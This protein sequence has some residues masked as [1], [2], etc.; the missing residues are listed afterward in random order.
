MKITLINLAN[1]FEF[2]QS[3]FEFSFHLL[4]LSLETG[5]SM[6]A[7]KLQSKLSKIKI[8]VSDVDGVLTDGGLYYSAE[9]LAFKK[10]NVKDGM[11]VVRLKELGFLTGIISTDDSQIIKIRAQ[12][13]KMNFAITGT[14]DKSGKVTELCRQNNLTLEN[15]AFIGDDV[16]D[17]DIMKIVG[18]CACPSDAIPEVR[19]IADYICTKSGGDAAFREF[20]ELIISSVN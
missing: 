8:V 18:F 12:K 14:W 2:K 13:L 6:I 5:E 15:V 20:A 19:Q 3:C 17:V 4:F 7:N 16:N 9:G 10:F 1:R 11:G